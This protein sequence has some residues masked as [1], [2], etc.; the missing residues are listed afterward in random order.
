M[1]LFFNRTATTLPAVLRAMGIEDRGSLTSP[2][3][4]PDKAL[5]N[6]AV[7][8]ALRL[9]ADL[10]SSTP[11]DIY[12]RVDGVQVE[13]PNRSR[14][15]DPTLL[16]EWLYSTQFDLD[17]FGNAFGIITERDR[18]GYPAVI[19][20]ASAQNAIVNTRDGEITSYRISGNEYEPRDVWHEKQ[21]TMAGLAVGLSPIAYAAWSVGTYLSAQEFAF[22]W[23]S[24]GAAPTGHLRNT[25]I[26]T[27]GEDAAE[28][29]KAKFKRA[30]R[31]RDIF[32]TGRDWEFNMQ[33]VP[34]NTVM[35]LDEMKYGVADVCRFLGIPGDLI[36]AEVSTGS[37]T[38]ANVT[39]RNLQL[40][41]MNLGPV[42]KRREAALTRA[43]PQPQF[44]KFNTDAM[45]RMDPEVRIRTILSQVA[46]RTLAPSEARALDNRS[47]F[48]DEQLAEF[49]R[50]FGT[51][52]AE[53]AKTGAPA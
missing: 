34:A 46:G 35:F 9:R 10:V 41:V 29:V 3:V 1:S 42:F 38:Y 28:S 6:S 25:L 21:Y 45:L 5:R 16:P 20:L 2:K 40:L 44:V 27:V 49:D 17:R 37:V 48:T 19:T 4:D 11:A 53:P 51:P 22:D 33:A 23:F 30:T 12:R 7:W 24:S 26:P 50:L 32:V 13:V 15:F 47:P 52:R 14:L 39:Q 36:D 8:A 18:A 31:D 43:L